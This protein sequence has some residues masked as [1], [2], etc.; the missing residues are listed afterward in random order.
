MWF[1][2]TAL[3]IRETA[4]WFRKITVMIW[5]FVGWFRGMCAEDLLYLSFL[6]F[7]VILNVVKNLKSVS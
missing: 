7:R 5:F 1:R 3:I 6:P 4:P 2:E